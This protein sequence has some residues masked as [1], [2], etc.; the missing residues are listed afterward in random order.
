MT[1]VVYFVRHGVTDHTGHRLSGWMKDV[2][3]SARGQEQAE[4]VADMLAGARLKA[5]YSS[6]IE[7]TVETARPIAAR[8]RLGV[9]IRRDLGE[10]DY[11]TWTNRSFR[12]LARTKLWST[13][14][15]YPSGVRFPQGETLREVQ[16][17]A[18]TEVERIAAR[19]PREAVCCVTHADVIRLVAAH[20]LGIHIDLFQRIVI[21]PASVSV[22][23]LHEEGPRVL[24]LN[25]SAPIPMDKTATPT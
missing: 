14:Q 7:R 3:L 2:H 11:G 18:V 6:P 16:T 10:V 22:V 8:H 17:R 1:S 4:A 13:V 24:S 5:V 19:H 15:R 23:A 25:T 20:F 21:G 12:S 9:R